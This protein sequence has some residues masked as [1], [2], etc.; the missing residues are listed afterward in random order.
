M[1]KRYLARFF[2]VA[3]SLVALASCGS[4]TGGG[5]AADFTTVYATRQGAL[6]TTGTG[7]VDLTT[8]S[9]LTA[10]YTITSTAYHAPNTG[11]TS[12]ITDLNLTITNVNYTL[13]PANTLSPA[14]P[15]IV[16]PNNSSFTPSKIIVGD[17]P[18]A[19]NIKT[20]DL[21]AFLQS[22]LAA[23]G[24]A[25]YW[26]NVTFTMQDIYGKTGSLSFPN[27]LEINFTNS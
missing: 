26:V 27:T 12:P 23:G 13:T 8:V 11:S 20:D 18:I 5:G 4:S 7:A 6:F 15:S 24:T 16:Q 10:T 1:L 21:K 2:C 9:P 17:N 25:S 22:K 14:L 19:I 3:C